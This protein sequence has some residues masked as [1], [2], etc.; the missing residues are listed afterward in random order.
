MFWDVAPLGF[1][2]DWF[3]SIDDLLDTLWANST[4]HFMI[5]YWSSTKSEIVQSW[6]GEYI[7]NAAGFYPTPIWEV[8]SLPPYQQKQS[9]Y[10][11][12]Q[13]ERPSPLDALRFRMGPKQGFLTLLIALGYVPRRYTR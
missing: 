4:H 5:E 2:F 10:N 8:S 9:I 6:S 11:R 7:S 1:V 13:E 3:L 12:Q